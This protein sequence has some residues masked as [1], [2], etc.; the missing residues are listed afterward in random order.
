MRFETSRRKVS[1]T[2]LLAALALM[3]WC[4]VRGKACVCG[5]RS[6][7]WRCLQ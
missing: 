2:G 5:C 6:S 4:G 7:G 3:V 1:N